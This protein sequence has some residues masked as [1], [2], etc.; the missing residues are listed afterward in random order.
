[1]LSQNAGEAV[2]L[3]LSWMESVFARLVPKRIV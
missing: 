1:M 2:V 3:L